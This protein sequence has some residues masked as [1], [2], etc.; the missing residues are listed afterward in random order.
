MVKEILA[1]D[2]MKSRKAFYGVKHWII[3]L[4]FESDFNKVFMI[5]SLKSRY[6][7]EDI[8]FFV[9]IISTIIQK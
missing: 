3:S 6:I 5:I 4:I 1:Y 9:I 2:K 7:W 8:L